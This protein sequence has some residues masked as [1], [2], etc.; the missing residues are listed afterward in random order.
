LVPIPDTVSDDQ[1]VFVGDVWS[2]GYHAAHEPGIKTGDEVVVFGCGPIGLAAVVSAQLF[3]PKRVFAVDT[4]A[5][6]L[7]IA[8]GYGAVP[9]NAAETDAVEFLRGA[10]AGR[11]VDV[12]IEAIGL[13]QTFLQALDSVRRGG[14][15][16]AVGLF[17]APFEIPMNRLP[18]QGIHLHMGLSNTSRMDRLMGL[19][20][21]GRVDLSPFVTHAFALDQA[22][23]AYDLFENRK[24]ECL[25]VLLKA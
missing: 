20:E 2:T 25:K 6:R 10:T 23:E 4:M 1:A 15:V 12:A 24:D 7:E 17:P 18:F 19:L 16:S 3:S 21:S 11:G 22:L 13:Q 5:N 9:V 8:A 14:A